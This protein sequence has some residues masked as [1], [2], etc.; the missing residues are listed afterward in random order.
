MNAMASQITGVSIVCSA[1]C[2]DA[3]QKTFKALRHW[4]LW[5]ESTGDA[6]YVSICWRHHVFTVS[7]I[8]HQGPVLI[9]N[10]TSNCKISQSTGAAR[11]G[12]EMLISLWN[13]PIVSA[14][15]PKAI[16]QKLM[17][18]V[19]PGKFEPFVFWVSG[20]NLWLLK[21]Y[22]WSRNIEISHGT[23]IQHIAI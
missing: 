12:V 10:E 2:S 16:L 19:I 6:E 22:D 8:L 11:F 18:I 20:L 9:S 13:L 5:G 23:V 14:A 15:V 1:V 4:L 17:F 7:Y 3:G 21:K